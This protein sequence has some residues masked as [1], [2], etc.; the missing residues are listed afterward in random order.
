MRNLELTLF[1]STLT[2]QWNRKSWHK[3]GIWSERN[4]TSYRKYNVKV[5]KVPQ[6]R[7]YSFHFILCQSPQLKMSECHSNWGG[8]KVLTN[9]NPPLAISLPS[10]PPLI[11]HW[12]GIRGL[13]L[14]PPDVIVFLLGILDWAWKGPPTRSTSIFVNKLKIVCPS[15]LCTLTSSA[16]QSRKL[17]NFS[18]IP[19]CNFLTLILTAYGYK[20]PF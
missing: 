11:Y 8:G 9:Q 15:A 1:Q 2:T 6:G 16:Y 13:K 10:P 19:I 12:H 5:L 4:T 7:G 20:E 14:S 18:P 3:T 17:Q